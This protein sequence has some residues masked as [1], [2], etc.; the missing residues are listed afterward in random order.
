MALQYTVHHA[1]PH[2]GVWY[3]RENEAEIKGLPREVRDHYIGLGHISEY[4][5]RQSAAE[6]E[7]PARTSA[8]EK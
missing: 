3:T 6:P 5:D 2:N 7:A 1:F 8:K 4:D